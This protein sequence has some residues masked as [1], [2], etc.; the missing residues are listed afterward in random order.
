MLQMSWDTIQETLALLFPPGATQATFADLQSLS[1]VFP[2]GLSLG[3][4]SDEVASFA[5]HEAR[6]AAV[7]LDA[8]AVASCCKRMPAHD[9]S[10]NVLNPIFLR[11]QLY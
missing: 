4:P 2:L 1:A 7:A 11:I 3:R 9:M 5:E 6:R 8:A 10:S